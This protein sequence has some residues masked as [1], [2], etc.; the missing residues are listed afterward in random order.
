MSR[1]RAPQREP[2]SEAADAAFEA[3]AAMMAK[4]AATPS[5]RANPYW[6]AARDSA[7][8]RFRVVFDKVGNP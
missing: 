8:A 3:Y 5:L 2:L 6:Q 4:E 7:F 1:P